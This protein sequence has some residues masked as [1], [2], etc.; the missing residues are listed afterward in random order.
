M[1]I[2]EVVMF[3]GYVN[4]RNAPMSPPPMQVVKNAI[5]RRYVAFNAEQSVSS[6]ARTPPTIL[7]LH[8]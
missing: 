7:M 5:C 2:P 8:T 6:L 1:N 3:A 4:K